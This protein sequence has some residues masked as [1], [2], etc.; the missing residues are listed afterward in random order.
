VFNNK[1]VKTV[2]E[3]QLWRPGQSKQRAKYKEKSCQRVN[4]DRREVLM[5]AEMVQSVSQD[6]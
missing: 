4:A 1:D 6:K 2:N 3:W 5:E